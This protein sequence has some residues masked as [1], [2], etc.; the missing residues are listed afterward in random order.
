LCT[1]CCS[2]K[3]NLSTPARAVSCNGLRLCSLLRP[4]ALLGAPFLN[5]PPYFTCRPSHKTPDFSRARKPSAVGK[6]I[7]RSRRTL[8]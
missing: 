8:Q 5:P 1:W 2:K 6:P 7:D 4:A 3:R